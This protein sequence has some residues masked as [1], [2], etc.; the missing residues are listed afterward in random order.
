MWRFQA[1]GGVLGLIIWGML[2]MNGVEFSRMHYGEIAVGT[3][4]LLLGLILF[5][6]E[7]II[8]KENKELKMNYKNYV[9]SSIGLL[10]M[11]AYLF[12][13]SYTY[14][15]GFTIAL[16]VVF[17]VNNGFEILKNFRDS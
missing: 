1:Y 17:Y 7:P 14:D 15:I 8:R 10:Y 3:G 4:V 9:F 6:A 5:Y 16:C 11:M 13:V 2:A 12:E